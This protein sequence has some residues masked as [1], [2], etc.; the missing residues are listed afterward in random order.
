VRHNHG[1]K[2]SIVFSI[3]QINYLRKEAGELGISIG[4]LVRRIIDEVRQN[5]EDRNHKISDNLLKND[6]E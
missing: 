1:F 3:P 6:G 4:E 2:R 5:D